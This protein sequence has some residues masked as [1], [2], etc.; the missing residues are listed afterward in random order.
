M[1]LGVLALLQS[2]VV[3]GAAL[4]IFQVRVVG[5]LALAFGV[6]L[7]FAVGNQGL[8][9]MLSAAARNELQAVQTIPLILFPSILLTGVFFPLESVPSGIR[10]FS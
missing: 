1:A 2:A 9:M 5:N 8:G 10:V 7:L 3:L 4:L 6:L